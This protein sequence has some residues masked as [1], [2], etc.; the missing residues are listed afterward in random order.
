[1]VI[2]TGK[3]SEAEQTQRKAL[4]AR[5]RMLGPDHHH[6]LASMNNLAITLQEQGKRCWGN[7]SPPVVG[8]D[9]CGPG[10]V[11]VLEGMFQHASVQLCA[12]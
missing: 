5:Q 9:A 11:S 10:S 1:M 7:S 2:C 3:H 6:T 8:A 12:C 4:E